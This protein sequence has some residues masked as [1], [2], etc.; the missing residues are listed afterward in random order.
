VKIGIIGC[1]NLGSSLIRGFLKVGALE[2]K[3]IMASDASE[4][5]LG[6][7]EKLGIE[8]TTNNK[9]LARCC[10]VILLAVKPDIVEPVLKEIEEASR[11]KL[12]ISAAAG[13]STG[14]IEAHTKARVIRIMP[15]IC[16]L[17]GEMASCFSL[18][19]RASR[20]DAELVRGLLNKIGVGFEIDEK[21]MDAVTGLSGSGPAY[22]YLIIKALRDAG[23]E[24]GLSSEVALK[25]AAQ[26][27]KGAGEMAL[28][29]GKGI[30][31]LTRQVCTPKGT[32]VEGLKVLEDRRISEALVAAVKAAAK[33]ARELSR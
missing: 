33:R 9:N 14:F 20:K 32:T 7:L 3:E 27:A 21:L 17:V 18:G 4:E 13:V 11:G 24:L 22:F 19:T 8:T 1:G 15:T 29:S 28:S 5:R 6:E 12:V 16:G 23:V 30:D 26:T 2:A 31:D 25:L 10:D